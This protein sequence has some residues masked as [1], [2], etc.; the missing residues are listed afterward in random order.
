MTIKFKQVLEILAIEMRVL[1][2]L[3][4]EKDLTYRVSTSTI[5]YS[6]VLTA[7]QFSFDGT[8]FR[9]ERLHI[10]ITPMALDDQSFDSVMPLFELEGKEDRRVIT[11]V[12]S[13][14]LATQNRLK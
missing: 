10:G 8:P 11:T 7:F 12:I 3:H 5:S 6:A 14:M 1:G 2:I 9:G 4:H 13:G